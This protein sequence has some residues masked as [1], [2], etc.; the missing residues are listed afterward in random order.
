MTATKLAP[1]QNDFILAVAELES[2]DADGKNLA[3]GKSV[4]ALD[5]IEAPAR[6]RKTNLTDGLF[7]PGPKLAPAEV[8]KLTAKRDA[9]LNAALGEKGVADLALAAK[10]QSDA[11]AELRKLPPRQTIYA[12][13]IHTGGGTFVGTGAG[14]G[15]PRPIFMLPRGDVTKPGKEVGPGAI[16]AIPGINGRFELPTTHTEGDRR[17]ALAKWLTDT[18]NPLTWRVMAN[19]VWQYHFGRGLVDTPNDFGKMGQFPRTPNCSTSSR[20]SCASISRLS[21][22]TSSS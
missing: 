13:A 2:L 10:E 4:T 15:K 5:S 19:R 18:N 14:G 7:P 9:M 17:A 1:R 8:A 6:W 11:D 12:G 20:P 21:N 16:A 22:S 3:A